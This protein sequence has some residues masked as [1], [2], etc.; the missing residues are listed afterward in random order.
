M[1]T[2]TPPR[3]PAA[4]RPAS[5]VGNSLLFLVF[6]Y[7]WTLFWY[8]FCEFSVPRGTSPRTTCLFRGVCQV[9]I[10]IDF[11]SIQKYYNVNS[12]QFWGI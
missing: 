5:G 11:A 3:W 8:P 9:P 7:I 1:W 2:C 12:N 4:A 6:F 10:I